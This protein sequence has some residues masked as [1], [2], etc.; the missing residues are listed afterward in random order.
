MC[1]LSSCK[2]TKS[3]ASCWTT[4]DHWNPPK[5]Y[6]ACPKTK[7]K[8]QQDGKRSAIT[9][10]SNP[11]P[12]G[13]VT[14]RLENDNIR[15]ALVLLWR[16]WT[17]CQAFQ[18]GDSTKGLGIPRESGLKSQW[19]LIIGLP[20]DKGNRDCSLG[21]HKLNFACTKTESRGAE[22]PQELNQSYWLVLEH[23]MKAWDS[24]GLPQRRGPWKVLLGINPLGV[25]P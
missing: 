13:W 9:K 18:P 6:N 14:H 15:E 3:A 24:R 7:K 19:D 1:A 21:G 23:L 11:I 8:P 12:T 4:I 20:E 5:K 10:N 22:T 17:S 2:G 16:F 25:L